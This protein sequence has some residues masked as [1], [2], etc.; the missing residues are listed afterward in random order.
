MLKPL[1]PFCALSVAASVLLSLLPHGALRKTAAMVAGL[2]AMMCWAESFLGLLKWSGALSPPV[3]IL[4]QTN[5]M[6]DQLPAEDA[7]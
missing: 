3:S 2:L 6:L 4:F 7:T 1:Y 5:Y